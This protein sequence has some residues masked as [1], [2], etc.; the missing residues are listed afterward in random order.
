MKGNLDTH[1]PQHQLS[2]RCVLHQLPTTLSLQPLFS[3]SADDLINLRYHTATTFAL[4][5]ISP[6]GPC[7]P[8]QRPSYRLPIVYESF[9]LDPSAR[10]R[11]SLG[12]VR[13]S[14]SLPRVDSNLSR[15]ILRRSSGTG[16]P[17]SGELRRKP[18][19][20]ERIADLDAGPP[21]DKGPWHK[22]SAFYAPNKTWKQVGDDCRA[23]EAQQQRRKEIKRLTRQ[24]DGSRSR[25][26]SITPSTSRVNS[27]RSLGSA[28]QLNSTSRVH[29]LKYSETG[30][31]VS[32]VPSS[33]SGRSTRLH[34]VESANQDDR[35]DQGHE[36]QEQQPR[37]LDTGKDCK[38]DTA[39]Y[40]GQGQRGFFGRHKGKN[41]GYGL[42]PS[43]K[44]PAN[45]S[46]RKTGA[47][48]VEHN[49]TSRSYLH[50]TSA[51]EESR[52]AAYEHLLVITE[53]LLHRL[54]DTEGITSSGWLPSTPQ[55]H[56][57]ATWHTASVNGSAA[58]SVSGSRR[59]SATPQ[60]MIMPPPER[61]VNDFHTPYSSHHIQRPPMGA[62][63]PAL[64]RGNSETAFGNNTPH[65]PPPVIPRTASEVVIQQPQPVQAGQYTGPRNGRV[66]WN[67]GSES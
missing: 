18:T 65:A 14:P 9:S 7:L 40:G 58:G 59:S 39:S 26:S 33:T 49:P 17:R 66:Q 64:V 55:S 42:A 45:A 20:A 22:D 44:S 10:P 47:A 35:I 46:S 27:F 56:H 51:K 31:T 3:A 25:S 29:S 28:T 23:W 1:L 16:T 41:P 11:P 34:E 38:Q 57:A 52:M 13:T 67:L 12:R 5:T 32:S 4:Y 54:M 36:A 6:C 63:V 53:D 37:K 21:I 60:E 62:T 61:F 19:L 8:V 30:S 2:V 50:C 24:L 15:S 43:L 48:I